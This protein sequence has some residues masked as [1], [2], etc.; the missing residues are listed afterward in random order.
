MLTTRSSAVIGSTLGQ[1]TFYTYLHL[2]PGTNHTTN[3]ISTANAIFYAGACASCLAITFYGDRI[4]RKKTIWISLGLLILG[5]AL[6]TGMRNLAMYQVSRVITGMGSGAVYSTVPVYQSEIS[7]PHFRGFLVGQAGIFSALGYA[8]AGW[9]G[10]GC[11]FA[12]ESMGEFGFRFPIGVGT[13]VSLLVL[14]M[15]FFLPESPRWLIEHGHEDRAIPLLARLH[16]D[17][18]SEDKSRF[19]RIEALAVSQQ[20]E[21]DLALRQKEGRFG[22]FTRPANLKRLATSCFIL[23]SSQAMGILVINNYSVSL[24]NALGKTGSDALLL[25]AGWITVTIP[26][27]AIAPLLIDRLGRRAMFC[28]LVYHVSVS[29]NRPKV[30]GSAIL[31]ISLAGETGVLAKFESTGNEAYAKAGIFF[32]YLFALGYGAFIDAASWVYAAEIWPTHRRATGNGFGFASLFLSVIVWTQAAPYGFKNIGW[33][34]YIVMLANC[35]LCFVVVLIW[36]PEVRLQVYWYR[37]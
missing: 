17:T 31:G 20:Y 32:L 13:I 26:C 29:A 12:A 1:P 5:S 7:P 24:Y 27:N 22:V 18:D 16:P 6:Q 37:E 19:A 14:V 34:Y 21:L 33:K 11:Y 30:I 25:T 15:S 35:V 23:W 4:G 2:T 28:K 10:Y 8:L 3:V 9:V 36:Y